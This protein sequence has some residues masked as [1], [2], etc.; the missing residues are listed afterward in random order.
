MPATIMLVGEQPGD[1]EDR[2]GHPFVGPAGK[3]LRSVLH[4]AGLDP[5][6]V[7]LTNAVKHFR[8]EE[9][10]K[11]RIHKTPGAMHVRACHPWLEAELDLVR[12]AVVVLLGATA[13]SALAPERRVTRDRGQT[14]PLLGRT[15]V[16]TTHP[17][18]VLRAADRHGARSQLAHDLGVAA[19]AATRPPPKRT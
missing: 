18:A 2:S 3:L 4:E 10:G 19:K 17:S 5:E 6:G 13:T 16:V 7:Y 8:W 14:F 1:V 15:G 12:P 11:R 9:R